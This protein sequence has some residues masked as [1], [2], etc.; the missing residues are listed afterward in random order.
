MKKHILALAAL[1][2]GMHYTRCMA[3]DM[4]P[5]DSV[6]MVACSDPEA[7]EAISHTFHWNSWVLV[8]ILAQYDGPP[9]YNTK[10]GIGGCELHVIPDPVSFSST[11]KYMYQLRPPKPGFLF[12]DIPV[13]KNQRDENLSAKRGLG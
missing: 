1:C 10:Q 6:F 5:E 4:P 11:G 13:R 12:Q 2:L 8:A 3:A 9:G 7:I